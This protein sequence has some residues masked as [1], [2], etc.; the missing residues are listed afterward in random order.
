MNTCGEGGDKDRVMIEYVFNCPECGGMA[1]NEVMVD[2]TVDTEIDK[3]T[4]EDGIV[5]GDAKNEDGEVVYFSCRG[6]G[7]ILTTDGGTCRD[8]TEGIPCVITHDEL[9]EWLKKNKADER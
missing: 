9:I 2:V 7:L 1:L 4:D 8:R 6:C 5:Y 3:V